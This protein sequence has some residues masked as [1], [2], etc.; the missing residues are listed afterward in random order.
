MDVMGMMG[1]I[2]TPVDTRQGI[3]GFETRPYDVMSDSHFRTN[4]G[5]GNPGATVQCW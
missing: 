1:D 2:L 4:D 5:G 3:G